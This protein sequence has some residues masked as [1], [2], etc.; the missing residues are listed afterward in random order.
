M[1]VTGGGMK[2]SK[3]DIGHAITELIEEYNRALSCDWVKDP[4][5]YALYY[6]WRRREDEKQDEMQILQISKE[7][8]E[9]P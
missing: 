4:V 8:R 7:L 3:N 9:R 6:T 2:S 5:Q 1:S